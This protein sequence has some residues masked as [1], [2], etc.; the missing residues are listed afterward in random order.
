M[1]GC[2]CGDLF[3]DGYNSA[4]WDAEVRRGQAENARRFDERYRKMQAVID[5]AKAMA[6]S[7]ESD[8]DWD[9]CDVDRQL[10]AAV[11]ALEEEA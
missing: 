9:L 3:C 7:I 1:S 4:C 11:R 8:P 6:Q 2:I 5:A 10:L